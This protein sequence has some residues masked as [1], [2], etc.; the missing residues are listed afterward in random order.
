MG[1]QILR[2][3]LSTVNLCERSA[4]AEKSGEDVRLTPDECRGVA[5]QWW[6]CQEKIRY[7]EA[8][9]VRMARGRE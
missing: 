7:L 5:E 4:A 1:V 6:V 8:L 3:L 2:T 9:I